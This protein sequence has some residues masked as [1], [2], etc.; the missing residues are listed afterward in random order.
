MISSPLAKF[1]NVSCRANPTMNPPI[2]TTDVL[3]EVTLVIWVYSNHDLTPKEVFEVTFEY[4][5]D[6][7]MQFLDYVYGA[8]KKQLEEQK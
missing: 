4:C 3:Y 5:M 1:P 6:E 7:S 8:A 2:T